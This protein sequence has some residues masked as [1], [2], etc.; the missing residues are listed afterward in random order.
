M[1]KDMKTIIAL[2]YSLALFNKSRSRAAD[3]TSY[4]KTQLAQKR[5]PQTV[6]VITTKVIC[7]KLSNSCHIV[8]KVTIKA[9]MTLL[10]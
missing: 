7:Q 2:H 9:L 10:Y 5:I 6:P 8:T 4:L 1:T 3:T